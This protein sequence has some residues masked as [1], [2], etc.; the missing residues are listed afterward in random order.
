MDR[1]PETISVGIDVSKHFWDLAVHGQDEVRRFAADPS[2]LK[3]LLA[4]LLKL[5]PTRICLE[6]TGGWERD[7]IGALHEHDLPGCVVNPRQVRDFARATGQLAKTDRID[8]LL[9]ARFAA[10]MQPAPS[11]KPSQNQQKLR[12]LRTRR[13][14][15]LDM[16]TQ[17][18]NRLVTVR[19]R[20]ARQ[21]IERAVDFYQEQ[22][23]SLDQ[24]MLELTNN[25]AHFRRRVELLTS[26]PGVGQVT[27]AAILADLP[28]LGRLNRREL[29]RLVGVAP[30]NRDSGTFRGKRRIG[31][32]R[33]AVRRGLY[34]ATLVAT[35]HN[36]V[37]RAFYHRLLQQG[38]AKKLA[39]TA[40][41]RKLLLMLNAI[42]K[43]KTPWR[44]PIAT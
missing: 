22:L 8:A 27:A 32:G 1:F 28:E 21:S 4:C 40:C 34:M 2:G 37:I 15:V 30:I 33:P 44:K 31:G 12:A 41:M 9:L 10:L 42:V 16:L 14:Q 35:K 11:E 13:Q 7:L 38:K 39:L 6:A 17:E 24:Q 23:K 5:Q 19:N 29:A 20:I 25:D 3:S 18:N 36:H 26:V 43:S